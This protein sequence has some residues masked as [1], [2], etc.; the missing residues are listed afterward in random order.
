MKTTYTPDVDR[1]LFAAQEGEDEGTEDCCAC[2]CCDDDECGL[3][4]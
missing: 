4:E 3:I 2:C 1:M